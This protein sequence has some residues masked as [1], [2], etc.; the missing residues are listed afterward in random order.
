MWV[1]GEKI[2]T[3]SVKKKRR[4][5]G[6]TQRNSPGRVNIIIE[7]GLKE[8][9]KGIPTPEISDL[10]KKNSDCSSQEGRKGILR[11]TDRLES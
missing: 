9:K 6:W 3:R 2:V 10:E 11:C 4:M 5:G 1:G 7:G 8:R